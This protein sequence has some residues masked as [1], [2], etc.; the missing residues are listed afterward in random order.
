MAL[1]TV[2]PSPIHH[3]ARTHARQIRTSGLTACG[4]IDPHRPSVTDLLMPP[5]IAL[6][7]LTPSVS[8]IYYYK[9]HGG[10]QLVLLTAWS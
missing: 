10:S 4:P 5:E 7:P 8:Y 1:V 2:A 3:T 6:P 9:D